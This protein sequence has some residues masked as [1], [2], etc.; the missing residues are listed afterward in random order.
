MI[1]GI[2]LLQTELPFET[3][4]RVEQTD[5]FGMTLFF[6][7]LILLIILLYRNPSVLASLVSRS[8]R[9][10]TEKLYFSA[11]AID[12]L[13]KLLLYLIYGCTSILSIYFFVE[14]EFDSSW[15]FALYLLPVGLVLFF[16]VPFLL[17][18]FVVGFYKLSRIILA[19]QSPLLFLFGLLLLPAGGFLFFNTDVLLYARSVIFILSILF[20]LWMHFRVFRELIVGGFP[21]YY[22]FVYF[23]T[24]EILPI[25]FIW[26]LITRF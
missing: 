9:N 15:R 20:V 7:G 18:A 2:P 10:D 21:V 22:I 17:T 23:C 11:P 25:A 24:L 3:V 8:F 6:L 13:D 5:W 14:Q 26:V 19:K 12:S 4:R 1:S 16:I